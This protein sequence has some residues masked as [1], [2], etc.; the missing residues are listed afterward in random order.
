MIARIMETVR[1]KVQTGLRLQP[2]LYNRLK[3]N[4]KKQRRSF[5]NYVEAILEAAVGI[6][7]PTFGKDFNASE[8]ILSLGDTLPHYTK[9]EIAS[10]ERLVYLLSK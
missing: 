5:N 10:D 1:V 6:E 9:E 8:E 2:E 7:Y 4:A 3:M